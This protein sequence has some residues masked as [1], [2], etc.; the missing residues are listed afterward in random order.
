MGY[1]TLKGVKMRKCISIGEALIDFIPNQKGVE[2]S[3]VSS[4]NK[5]VGG[6]PANVAA[7]VSA[8]GGKSILLTALG[9]DGFG[10][11]IINVLKQAKV[12]T[13]YIKRTSKANTGLAFVTNLED[14]NRE[15]TFYRNPSADLLYSNN[16]VPDVFEESDVLHFCS[17]DLIPSDMKEA[18]IEAIKKARSNKTI[19]SFDPNVRLPLWGDKELCKNTINDFIP[20]ADVLKI[21]DEELEFI[22]GIKDVNDAIK[23]LFVGNV[24]IVIYTKGSAGATI[25]TSK[26]K[27]TKTGFKI[28]AVDTTG[29]GDSFIGAVIFKILESGITVNNI[30]K[31][32]YNEI[33]VFANAVGA[34][35]ASRRGALPMPNI[36][37]VNNFLKENY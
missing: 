19:V 27:Y 29:A 37:E 10:T 31:L 4:F 25:Y 28:N 14:G 8:L 20:K 9:E 34:L 1:C 24:K 36:Q 2:L 6:A 3:E 16:D 33:L 26:E 35:V 18:H 5:V 21:S 23:S 7:C 22:T 13:K 15:F 32:D 30:D 12:E 17:V 11:H